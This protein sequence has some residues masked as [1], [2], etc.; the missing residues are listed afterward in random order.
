[1]DRAIA[2]VCPICRVYD[3]AWLVHHRW[4][5]LHRGTGAIV[6]PAVV[7]AHWRRCAP[8]VREVAP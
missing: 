6:R 1:M 8:V 4:C 2:N 3:P 7:A 5:T